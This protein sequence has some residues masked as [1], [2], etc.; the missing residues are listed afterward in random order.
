[1]TKLCDLYLMETVLDDES[2][3]CFTFFTLYSI[4]INSLFSHEL[5]VV[6]E[7]GFNSIG[8]CWGFH[9]WWLGQRQGQTVLLYY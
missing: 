5:I 8:K 1:M 7:E 9:V 4:I 2:E 3:V 6:A